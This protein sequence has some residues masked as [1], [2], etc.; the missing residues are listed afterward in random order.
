MNKDNE[1]FIILKVD[2]ILLN[3]IRSIAGTRYPE[4]EKN[5]SDLINLEMSE[6]LRRYAIEK[7]VSILPGRDYGI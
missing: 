6:V 2:R 4:I 5:L 3:R 7:H 1:D